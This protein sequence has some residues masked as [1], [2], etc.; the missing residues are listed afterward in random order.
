[1]KRSTTISAA[2]LFMMSGFIG[3]NQS[4]PKSEGFIKVDITAIYYMYY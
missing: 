4:K 2:I 1:M 3:C